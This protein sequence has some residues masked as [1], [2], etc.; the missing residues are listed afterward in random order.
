MKLAKL[1]VDITGPTKYDSTDASAE[2]Y[3]HCF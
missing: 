2:E 1:I 3:T